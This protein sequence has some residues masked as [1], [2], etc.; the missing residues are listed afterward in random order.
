MDSTAPET[1]IVRV[2]KGE[3]T[4]K[5][6]FPEFPRVLSSSP[7]E[8]IQTGDL[9]DPVLVIRSM[10]DLMSMCRTSDFF[11]EPV[12]MIT[13]YRR[14]MTPENVSIDKT[15][16]S[17]SIGVGLGSIIASTVL[18]LNGFLMMIGLCF[19]GLGIVIQLEK[20]RPTI[21]DLLERYREAKKQ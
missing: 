16:S 17:V 4:S 14:M 13:V 5:V 18:S 3:L 8:E 15:V 6:P 20:T 2:F 7:L 21:Q 12:S 19:I 1:N 10:K 9:K 11:K